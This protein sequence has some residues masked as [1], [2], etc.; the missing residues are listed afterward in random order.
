LY[1]KGDDPAVTWA[2]LP[3]QLLGTDEDINYWEGVWQDRLDSLH[4]I[5]G[6]NKRHEGYHPHLHVHE[7]LDLHG[8]RHGPQREYGSHNIAKRLRALARKYNSGRLTRDDDHI[9]LGYNVR[10]LSKMHAALRTINHAELGLNP[11]Y[12][13]VL[14]SILHSFLSRRIQP[15]FGMQAAALQ[16]M[17]SNMVVAGWVSQWMSKLQF[18]RILQDPF[19]VSLVPNWAHIP[20]PLF[21]F[22][23]D[24]PIRTSWCNYKQIATLTQEEVT[25]ILDT[26]CPCEMNARFY[27]TFI[28]AHWQHVCTNDKAVLQDHDAESF[29]DMGALFRPLSHGSICLGQCMRDTIIADVAR[30]VHKYATSVEQVVGCGGCMQPWARHVMQVVR[31]LVDTLPQHTRMQDFKADVLKANDYVQDT[32][33]GSIHR[34]RIAVDSLHAHF[35]VSF[36]DKAAQNFCV[37]CTKGYIQELQKDLQAPHGAYHDVTIAHPDPED[38][39]RSIHNH[40]KGDGRFECV[41]KVHPVC[42]L[43]F[44]AATCK[45]HKDPVKLRFLSCSSNV[46]LTEPAVYVTQFFRGIQDDVY[47]FWHNKMLAVG[48]EAY[49]GYMYKPWFIPA[50][51]SVLPTVRLFNERRMPY[52]LFLTRGAQTTWDFNRL[53]TNL[54]QPDLKLRM[55]QLVH[56]VFLLHPGKAAVRVSRTK[57]VPL[58][59]LEHAGPISSWCRRDGQ[60]RKIRAQ[61][62]TEQSL[63]YLF[64]YIIDHTYVQ[65]GGHLYQQAIGIPMG[66]NFAV[67][68]S[69]YYLFT[70]EYDFLHQ[71]HQ[72]LDDPALAEHGYAPAATWALLQRL[73][74][75]FDLQPAPHRVTRW[76][77]LQ[78]QVQ[79]VSRKDAA[80]MLLDAYRYTV[81]Y[82]DDLLSIANPAFPHLLYTS[83]RWFGFKGLYPPELQLSPGSQG[84]KVVYMDMYLEA[85]ATPAKGQLGSFVATIET[86]LYDK[87]I[88]GPLAGLGIIKYPHITSNLSWQ[89]KYNIL[90]T[91]FYRLMRNI[92][93]RPNFCLHIA[94]IIFHLVRRGYQLDLLLHRLQHLLQQ[95]YYEWQQPWPQVF[96]EILLQLVGMQMDR[97]L[98]GLTATLQRYL[99]SVQ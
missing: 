81:R 93:Q 99:A 42:K 47:T 11:Q 89:C 13:A 7:I 82:V 4:P 95:H 33:P 67:H 97:V 88:H 61:V 28:P 14:Q 86:T 80:R 53:F 68:L 75:T 44:Y 30:A 27:N 77:P 57:G 83:S 3:L 69:N 39:A 87:C 26:P 34:M 46:V 71:L 22:S 98:P 41:V 20:P 92:T 85:L 19:T 56:Q 78:P 52:P 1:S 94:R 74:P 16:D 32:M 18:N 17:G 54:P 25:S 38:L 64:D 37:L 63:T 51:S 40:L 96:R 2:I 24:P 21:A 76:E 29:W 73:D 15:R 62:F 12:G 43:P 10:V 49:L 31:Q 79:E 72:V 65:F 48:F 70:Y 9:L 8:N 36:V 66:I 91:E 23:Y 55:A 58:E 6:Y 45:F 35:T 59:W 50:S 90:T 60:G 5:W 84:L